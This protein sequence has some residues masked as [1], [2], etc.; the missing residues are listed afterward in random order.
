MDHFFFKIGTFY[1]QMNKEKQAEQGET[2]KY[3][4]FFKKV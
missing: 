3:F 1:G 4:A 2:T